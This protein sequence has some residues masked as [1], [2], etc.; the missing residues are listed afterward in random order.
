MK[1]ASSTMYRIGNIFT[2]IELVLGPL[3][4]VIGLI[5]SIIGAVQ[6]P[7][8]QALLNSGS[9]MIGWG[10]YFIIVSILCLVFVSKAQRELRNR[11]SRNPTPFILTIVF[12]AIAQNVFY[13]LAGIFGLI[14]DS[15]QGQKEEPKAVEEKPAEEESKAE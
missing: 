3:F 7:V 11:D 8:N 12:G 14:A 10:V 1:N 4:F 2:I 9:T 6:D 5:L 13:V 15:Q